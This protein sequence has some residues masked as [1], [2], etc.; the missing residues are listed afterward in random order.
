MVVIAILVLAACG[1]V[2]EAFTWG[3]R[4]ATVTQSKQERYDH[5]FERVTRLVDPS[6]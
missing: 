1:V 5:R 3:L 4:N 6:T 2:V